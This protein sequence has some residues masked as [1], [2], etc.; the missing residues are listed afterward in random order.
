MRGIVEGFYGPPWSH[1]ARLELLAFVARTR[2][3]RVRVRAEGRREAPRAMARAVRRRRDAR[4]SPSSRPRAR[5]VGMRFGFARLAR[6]RHHLRVG[7]PTA[8]VLLDKLL[9][10]PTA[11]S[12]GSSCSLDDIPMQPGLAPR[13]AEL[14]TA[15]LDALRARS[16]TSTLTVCPTEYVG[17]RP[18]PYL[19]DARRGPAARRRRHVD[20]PD[21]VLADDHGRR[22][23]RP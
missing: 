22:R 18:S 6:P 10:S 19:A 20:R 2:H 16:R 15:L 23:T 17:T 13:Q 14:A 4:A 1:D 21:R 8:H 3:E 5:D 7:R 11:A 9:R 12:R